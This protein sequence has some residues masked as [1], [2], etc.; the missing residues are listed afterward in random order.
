MWIFYLLVVAAGAAGAVFLLTL[1]KLRAGNRRVTAEL[2]AGRNEKIADIGAV[3]SLTVLPL[4]DFYTEDP[5]LKTEAGVSYLVR[6]DE[7]TLLMDV[8]FNKKKEHPSPLLH[9]MNLLGVSP[10]DIDAFFITH[11]HLDHVGG[12][13]EQRRGLFSISQGS[14]DVRPVPV[15]SPAPIAPSPWNP[16]PV[17]EIV[18]GPRK[19]AP[20]VA[21][22]GVIP[23]NLYLM[24]YT[25]EHSL[26]VNVE[27]KGVIVIIGCGHQTIERILERT[28]ALFDAPIYGIIGGLH[29]PVNG[30][31]I[32]L[33]PVNVQSLV[34]NDR[35]PWKGISEAD[36]RSALDAIKAADPRFV[37]LSAHDSSDW[38]L[39]LFKNSLGDVCHELKVGQAMTF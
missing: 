34:G 30:G 31:R 4:V 39:A 29:F 14:V 9:N 37:A 11:L 36:V 5:R 19:L 1:A 25:R 2:A 28:A 27:G 15:Y 16:G 33:G 13:A 6:A 17:A 20:G 22:I 21:T 7:T 12:L 3:K 26:A 8:G 38:A 32:M 10:R 18:D 23:R 24:G 35:P